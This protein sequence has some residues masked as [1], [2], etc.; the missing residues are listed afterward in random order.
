MKLASKH[1]DI[2]PAIFVVT[3]YGS[4][5]LANFVFL[6]SAIAPILVLG[7]GILVIATSLASL[8]RAN[9]KHQFKPIL[10]LNVI[11]LV[12]PLVFVYMWLNGI[13]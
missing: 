11:L 3:M 7:S 10:I 12:Q 4:F 2:L 8:A 5:W 6:I 13:I 9:A 1:L